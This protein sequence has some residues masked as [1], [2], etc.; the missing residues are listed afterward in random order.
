M[1][2]F[3]ASPASKITSPKSE[4]YYSPTPIG[5]LIFDR[6]IGLEIANNY[7]PAL[8]QKQ[9]FPYRTKGQFGTIPNILK[10]ALHSRSS[11]S[12]GVLFPG[13]YLKDK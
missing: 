4:G 5:N 10:T 12:G 6:Y 11:T 3:F 1:L 2:Y 13:K 9:Y 7:Y 8:A